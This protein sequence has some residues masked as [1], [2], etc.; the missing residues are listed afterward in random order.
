MMNGADTYD[1]QVPGT[2]APM[3]RLLRLVRELAEGS[4]VAIAFAIAILAMGTPVALAVRAFHDIV[5]WLVRGL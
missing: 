3:I 5:L 1:K 2:A 4:V